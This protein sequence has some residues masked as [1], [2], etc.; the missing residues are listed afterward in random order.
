MF[1]FLFAVLYSSHVESKFTDILDGIKSRSTDVLSL[2][3]T[4]TLYVLSFI[5][6]SNQDKIKKGLSA[7]EAIAAISE[8]LSVV[9]TGEDGLFKNMQY[10]GV[11]KKNALSSL[12]II[13]GYCAAM[14]AIESRY[15]FLWNRSI[16]MKKAVDEIVPFLNLCK[17]YK[18]Y[19]ES[20]KDCLRGWELV[21]RYGK[22]DT[23]DI[24]STQACIQA[25][26]LWY[27]NSNEFHLVKSVDLLSDD[28]AHIKSF[29]ESKAYQQAY[30]KLYSQLYAFLPT[31]E[32]VL[33]L[34]KMSSEYKAEWFY[35]TNKSTN[36]STT[37]S[38]TVETVEIS[39]ENAEKSNVWI[40]RMNPFH[41]FEVDQD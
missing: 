39:V 25:I 3:K 19:F 17:L 21:E 5:R 23:I 40:Q 24:T 33:D 14:Q 22:P 30:P 32:C 27:K 7:K 16:E 8:R 29:L 2:A 4:K 12:R 1:C 41:D 31:L 9:A 15:A 37:A 26:S 18:L 38:R 13:E 36:K 10:L 28:I 20:H 34:V 11:D 6:E 35:K